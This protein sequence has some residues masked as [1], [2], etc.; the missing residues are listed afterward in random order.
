MLTL[1]VTNITVWFVP[2]WERFDN[3]LWIFF[4][5][6]TNY[7]SFD[8][9]DNDFVPKTT[10]HAFDDFLFHSRLWSIVTVIRRTSQSR[11]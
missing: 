5:N 6:N 7:G 10:P 8:S 3:Y 1:S 2:T 9:S 11:L 4:N